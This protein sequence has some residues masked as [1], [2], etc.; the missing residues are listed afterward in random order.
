MDEENK[1]NLSFMEKL[2]GIPSENQP[3]YKEQVKKEEKEQII[4]QK[5][6]KNANSRSWYGGSRE[7]W[8]INEADL[9]NQVD[10]YK[11]LK[12]TKSYRGIAILT[13]SALLGFSLLLSFFGVITD[14]TTMFWAIIMYLP[15]IFFVYKG[16]RWAI[17]LLMTLWTLD[18]G[19]Q[20]IGQSGGQVEIMPIIGWFIFTPFFWRAL[21]VENER[22]RINKLNRVSQVSN[23]FCSHCGSKIEINSKFCPHCGKN[24][25]IIS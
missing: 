14:P 23:Q 3:A 7:D 11:T 2:T 24:I 1:S 12:I 17:I 4:K 10:N 5:K 22:K 6:S 25:K 9:K 8:K 21:K 18:K 15:I 19:Y 13:I 16:H 20:V